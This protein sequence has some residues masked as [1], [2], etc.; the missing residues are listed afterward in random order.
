MIHMDC[1]GFDLPNLKEA[2]QKIE[3]KWSPFRI[4][5]AKEQ[6]LA[7]LPFLCTKLPPGFPTNSG[8]SCFLLPIF[9]IMTLN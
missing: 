9:Y 3:E 7:F 5:N 8:V 1:R 4:I 2:L 6:T